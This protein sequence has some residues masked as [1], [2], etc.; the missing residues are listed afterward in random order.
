MQYH[1][2]YPSY[3]QAYD[4]G[5]Y[6]LQVILNSS[7]KSLANFSPMP[8]PVL[9]WDLHTGNLLITEQLNYNCKDETNMANTMIPQ[10]NSE[11][12]SSYNAILS[13]VLSGSSK[14]FFL[15]GPGGTGKTFVY[16]TLCHILCGMGQIVICLASSGI[17]TLLPPSG[18][19]SHS[20]GA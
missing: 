18:H 11:Q 16:H 5:L 12:Q 8:Q 4:L 6:L 14:T 17:A 9:N 2:N 13:A 1:I 19:T 3:D 20:Q 15:S 10:L 7:G